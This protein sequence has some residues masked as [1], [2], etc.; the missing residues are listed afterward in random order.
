MNEESIRNLIGNPGE[1]AEEL[2]S[3]R[4]TAD[5][6]SSRQAD[7]VSQYP[8]S[9]VAVHDGKIVAGESTL[10]GVLKKLDDLHI[11][12]QAAMIRFIDRTQRK[13]ILSVLA[14]C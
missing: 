1:L 2:R 5:V 8:K 7:L 9:W 12:P 14:L 3:F 11:S 6:F 13:M 10:K 4:K